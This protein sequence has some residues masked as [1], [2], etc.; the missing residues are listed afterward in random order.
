M[1]SETSDL[2]LSVEKNICVLGSAKVDLVHLNFGGEQAGVVARHVNRS[3]VKWLLD[4]FE[5][6][7]CR[8]LEPQHWIPVIIQRT[9]FQQILRHNLM[10]NL[11]Q[12][13]PVAVNLPIDWKLQCLQGRV[14]KAAAAEWLDPNDQWWVV[15]FYDAGGL[16]PEALRSLQEYRDASQE[17]S[18]GEICWNMM[19]HQQRGDEARVGEWLARWAG[20]PTYYRNF[21]QLQNGHRKIYLIRDALDK[22][23]AFPGLWRSWN[24][25][26]LNFLLPMGCPEELSN[27]LGNIWKVWGRIMGDRPELLDADSVDSLE[28]RCPFLSKDDRDYIDD[29]F[30]EEGAVFPL[31]DKPEDRALLHQRLIQTET[32]IP[33]FRTFIKDA[34]QLDPIAKL[35][36]RFQPP[37][38]KG[39]VQDGMKRCYKQPDHDFYIQV[40]EVAHR[41]EQNEKYYGFWAAYRQV[42]LSAMR[43]F[44]SLVPGSQPLKMHKV[45]SSRLQTNPLALWNQFANLSSSVGFVLRSTGPFVRGNGYMEGI[46]GENNCSPDTDTTHPRL[47]CNGLKKWSISDCC[48]MTDGPSYF[49]DEKYLYLDNIYSHPGDVPQSQITSFAV[50]RNFMLVFF[51]QFERQQATSTD[52]IFKSNDISMHNAPEAVQPSI[53]VISPNIRAVLNTHNTSAQ[54][55]LSDIIVPTVVAHAPIAVTDVN[56]NNAQSFTQDAIHAAITEQY[57]GWCKMK[58]N[59][60]PGEFAAYYKDI[61]PD[62]KHKYGVIFDTERSEI[63]CVLNVDTIENP[64]WT[65]SDIWCATPL[66]EGHLTIVA[67]MAVPSELRTAKLIFIGSTSRQGFQQRLLFPDYELKTLQE[68]T[69]F[70]EFKLETEQWVLTSYGELLQL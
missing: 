63:T 35:L 66:R 6:D 27:G 69:T 59:I 52:V 49:S 2:N 34:K 67:P 29:L 10:T 68:T 64:P 51:P 28:G 5:T 21:N 20:H 48:G 46:T 33:S 7:R 38:Y 18:S 14:R 1:A 36:K 55:S 12:P 61:A 31:F 26:S 24:M 22:L 11:S 25:G 23:H 40:S 17:L 19:Y 30:G 50:K 58:I 53:R 43:H 32:I 70:P 65:M 42:V 13:F 56:M 54:P 44:F 62:L 57:P 39:T 16:S 15:K 47:T 60:S 4:K 3:N 8:R 9:A 41:R 37:K 45:P